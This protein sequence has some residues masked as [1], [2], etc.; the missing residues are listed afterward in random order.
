MPPEAGSD[1]YSAK[2][3]KRELVAPVKLSESA[4]GSNETLR[5]S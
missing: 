3:L 5:E 1:V 2:T 4:S